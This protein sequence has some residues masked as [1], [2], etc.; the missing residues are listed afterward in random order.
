MNNVL[1]NFDSKDYPS[2]PK[3]YE[4]RSPRAD[5]APE[6]KM[7]D[8]LGEHYLQAGDGGKVH[9]VGHLKSGSFK[10]VKDKYYSFVTV[11]KAPEGLDLHKYMIFSVY[12]ESFNAGITEFV[13]QD[14]GKA[15]GSLVFKS[16]A[17]MDAEIRIYYRIGGGQP[18]NVYSFRLEECPPPSPRLVKV[19]CCKGNTSMETWAKVLDAVGRKGAD[20]FLLPETFNQQGSGG[21]TLEG[22][23][24]KLMSDK[25]AEYGMYVT[26][27]LILK[28]AKDGQHY[29][30]CVLYN[31]KGE[32]TGCYYKH[33][34]FS[35]EF[36]EQGVYPGN[37]VPVFE[38]DFGTIGILIC[39]DSWFVDVSQL[40]SL[41]GAEIALFPNAGYY[42]SLMPARANDNCMRLVVS[43]LGTEIG[44]WDTAGRDVENPDADD[45]CSANSEGG[46]FDVSREEVDGVSI[47]YATLDLNVSPSAHNWGGNL[48]SSPGSR[49]NRRDTTRSLW[50]EIKKEDAKWCK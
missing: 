46:F 26:G 2:L 42:R 16:P 14:C 29:N 28:D 49:R 35:P 22:E 13:R 37:E 36:N 5:L 9:C 41:K 25:A 40:L 17:D 10:L 33:H 21:E 4:V 20:I 7:L 11:I 34:P 44:I 47:L 39:Y 50:D 30:A 12:S 38:T 45:S 3:G 43:S 27:T 48:L 1:I 19:A 8:Y 15:K 6:F 31:R 32:Y 18:V 23:S 24:C